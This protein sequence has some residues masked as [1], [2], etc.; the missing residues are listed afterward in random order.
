MRGEEGK[1]GRR[2]GGSATDGD[3]FLLLNLSDNESTSNSK[4]PSSTQQ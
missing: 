3:G 2:G 1:E 4:Q